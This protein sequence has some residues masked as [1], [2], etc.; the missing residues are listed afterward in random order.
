MTAV[1]FVRREARAKLPPDEPLIPQRAA[2]PPA[3]WL[4]L[5]PGLVLLT[6][7]VL[8]PARLERLPQLHRVARHQAAAS[9]SASTTGSSSSATPSSGRRSATASG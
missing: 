4:Y 1:P 2:A 3:Y 8:D 7:V 6:V 9:S 5:L